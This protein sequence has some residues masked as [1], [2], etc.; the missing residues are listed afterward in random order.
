MTSKRKAGRGAHRLATAWVSSRSFL[1]AV[2]EEQTDGNGWEFFVS[3]LPR[4]FPRTTVLYDSV[5]EPK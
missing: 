4:Q 3:F 5:V 2:G 1:G